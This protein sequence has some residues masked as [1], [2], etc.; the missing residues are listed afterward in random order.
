MS[1]YVRVTIGSQGRVFMHTLMQLK[2]CNTE[3]IGLKCFPFSS[4]FCTD[5]KLTSICLHTYLAVCIYLHLFTH[6]YD[7]TMIITT[8]NDSTNSSAR[9]SND[10]TWRRALSC[11]S[12]RVFLVKYSEPCCL[13]LE[14]AFSYNSNDCLRPSCALVTKLTWAWII[15]DF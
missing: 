8:C 11:S 4:D 1:Y 3:V 6:I 13:T 14:E 2:V 7:S 9:L 10:C 15:N 5:Y 12:Y